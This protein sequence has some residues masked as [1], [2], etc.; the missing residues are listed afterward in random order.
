LFLDF[1]KKVIYNATVIVLERA[2][3]CSSI[4]QLII[5][6]KFSEVSNVTI[7]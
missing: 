6:N 4:P 5:E 3:P 1:L 7:H 2:L